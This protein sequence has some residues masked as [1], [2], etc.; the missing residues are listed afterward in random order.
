[1]KKINEFI[2]FGNMEKTTLKKA[3]TKKI[4]PIPLDKNIT[5]LNLGHEKYIFK[6]PFPVNI[7]IEDDIYIASSYDLNT[8]GYGK[9]EDEA[10]RDLCESIIEYYEHLKSNRPRLGELL[11]RDWD[12]LNRMILELEQVSCK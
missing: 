2:G 6:S 10:I 7:V 8:F 9:T 12:F 3:S 5:I 11:Q 4:K 1:M